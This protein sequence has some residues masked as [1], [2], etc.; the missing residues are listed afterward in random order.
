MDW[1]IEVAVVPV[2]DIDRAKAFYTEQ[3]GFTVDFDTR[4]DDQ[5]G[6]VQLT[7]PGSSCSIILGDGLTDMA[8]GSLRCLWLVVA[9]LRAARETLVERQVDVSEFQMF[10][11]DAFRAR[12]DGEDLD[13]TGFAF[14]T[15]PDGN[16]WGVQQIS[17]RRETA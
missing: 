10:D 3:L 2:S 6:F 9:D 12:R 7:P 4:A 17:A 15:D 11:A 5:A 13:L 14:F 1:T 16:R 8:P